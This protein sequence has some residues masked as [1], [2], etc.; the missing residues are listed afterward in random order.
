MSKFLLVLCFT[1]LLSIPIT[2][3]QNEV[4]KINHTSENIAAITTEEKL[5]DGIWWIY[6]YEDGILINCYPEYGSYSSVS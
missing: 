2:T 6:V 4:I 3:S 1:I 5:I